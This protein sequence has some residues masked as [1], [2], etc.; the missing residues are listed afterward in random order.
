MKKKS[1]SEVISTVLL[2]LLTIVATG[3]IIGFVV[4]FV[5]KQLDKTECHNY[6][7]K[8]QIRED[9]YT[10][11]N[12]LATDPDEL[13]VKIGVT[14]LNKELIIKG[15]VVV[16][17]IG[18]DS[19]KISFMNSTAPTGEI[20]MKSDNTAK[21]V[22]PRNGEERTYKITYYELIEKPKDITV[23]PIINEDEECSQAYD[24]VNF[25]ELCSP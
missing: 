1:Q 5:T 14:D 4:P 17:N 16:V 7:N 6:L 12:N 8:V 9:E 11:Y 19:K 3:I 22:V 10:C 20:M 2:I 13:Y 24:K 25:V 23:Y 18:G 21:L 15:L